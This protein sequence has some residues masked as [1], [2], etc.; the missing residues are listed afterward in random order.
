MW[1]LIKR[2][3]VSIAL[4]WLILYL[5]S[6]YSAWW[7]WPDKWF[8]VEPSQYNVFFTFG[9][10]AAIFWVV[11][12]IVKYILKILTIPLKYLTLGLFSFVLNTMMIYMFEFLINNSSM[13]V[14]VH[15]WTIIQ[16]F[17][18]SLFVVLVSFLIKKIL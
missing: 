8:W 14:T 18:L 13:W 3:V 1:K 15:L 9:I 10:L 7:F 16:V 11:N 5:V 6:T 17:I 12:N 4:Y 2:L